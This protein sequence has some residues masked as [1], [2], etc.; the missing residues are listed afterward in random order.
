MPYS[1]LPFR[2]ERSAPI[3]DAA[4][5]C[6]I[7]RYFEDLEALFVRHQVLDDAEKKRAAVNYPPIE[8][9]R[10]WK[11]VHAFSNPARTYEDFKEEVIQLYPEIAR[12]RMHTLAEFEE[13]IRQAVRKDIR[14]E[15]DLGV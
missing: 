2:C 9:E 15:E 10:L 11:Y 12:D 3:L 14:S 13:A 5:P 4:D 1:D 8:V 6:T 7:W